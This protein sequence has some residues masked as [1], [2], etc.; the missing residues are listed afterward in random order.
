MFENNHHKLIHPL[1]QFLLFPAL[2]LSSVIALAQSKHDRYSEY[3]KNADSLLN[4]I[5]DKGVFVKYVRFQA[6]KSYYIREGDKIH[7]KVSFSKQTNWDPDFYTFVYNFSHPGFPGHRFP[8]VITLDRFGKFAPHMPFCG[9][10]IIP[11]SLDA[12][13][14]S[15]K[16]A[17][18][19]L[20]E[21]ESR[22]KVYPSSTQLVWYNEEKDQVYESVRELAESCSMKWR[23]R[24]TV[25][26]RDGKK[27]RGNFL[28]D[29][30]TGGIERRFAIPWD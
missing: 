28:V 22:S 11:D 10:V 16:M 24:G 2:L 26:F 14:V 5:I 7:R 21:N 25:L 27:Y 4:T 1:K 3:K 12:I 19:S 17:L 20:K 23:V 15:K 6:N 18:K 13:V 30:L 9:L 29:V 8:I